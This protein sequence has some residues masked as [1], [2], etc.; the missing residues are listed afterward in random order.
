VAP[1]ELIIAVLGVWR[2]THL[3]VAEDG[4][5][6]VV[7]RLRRRAG[8]GFWGALLDCFQCASLWI[9]LPFA[10]LG[11]GTWMERGLLWL[12]LSGGAIVIE[13]LAAP[14]PPAPFFEAPAEEMA[15]GLLRK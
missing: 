10:Y 15:D 7:T 5:W 11:G 2:V 3:L 1:T 6:D 14:V 8:S 13:R 4:P 9:A 12:A